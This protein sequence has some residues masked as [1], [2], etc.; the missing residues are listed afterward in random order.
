[1]I[2]FRDTVSIFTRYRWGGTEYKHSI[3]H[4]FMPRSAAAKYPV[5]LTPVPEPAASPTRVTWVDT[6]KGYGIILVVFAHAVR[7]LIASDIMT[8]TPVTRFV[9]AW[10][11]AFHMP[12]FFVLSGFFL[13]R[14]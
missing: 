12:L 9:D 4:M 11:Y 1:M 7:G 13:V 14:S 2:P 8:W 10:I 5:V 3:E 6:A